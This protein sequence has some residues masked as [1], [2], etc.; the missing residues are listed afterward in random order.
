MQLFGT[1]VQLP[2]FGVFLRANVVN[3]R[4]WH[5]VY[6][7]PL[8]AELERLGVPLSF[9]QGGRVHLPQPGDFRD[10]VFVHSEKRRVGALAAAPSAPVPANPSGV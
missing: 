1:T 5:D 6:D 7:D 10:Q 4:N 2:S 3:G 8:W 9:H